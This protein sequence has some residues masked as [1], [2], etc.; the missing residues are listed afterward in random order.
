MKR[1]SLR[2]LLLALVPLLLV[3]PSLLPGKRFLPLLP[4]VMEPLTAEHPEAAERAFE[5]ANRVATD[6]LFPVLGEEREIREQ[7][8]AGELPT[9]NP[10]LGAGLPLA[11]GSMAAP[12]NPLRW[13]FLLLP[14]EV[15]GGWHVLLALFLA[16]LGMLLFL[17]RRGLAPV[18]AL[19]GAI[20]FQVGGFGAANLHYAMK[21]D[22][23]LWLPWCLWAVD[24][25]FAGRRFAGLALFFSLGA[26]ALAGFPPIFVFVLLLGTAWFVVRALTDERRGEARWRRIVGKG[27]AFGA[28]GILAGGVHLLPML[29]ASG[30][31]T[32]GPLEAREIG[33]QALPPAALATAVIP[34]L[35]GNAQEEWAAPADPAVWW[36]TSAVDR[37]R[38][39][40]ANRLEWSLFVGVSVVALA[41]SALLAATRRALFPALALV[42]VAFFIAGDPFARIFYS[43]PGLDL[44]NPARAGALWWFLFPW[45]A[46]LG[47]DALLEEKRLARGALGIACAAAFAL[48]FTLWVAID[49]E[50]WAEHLDATLITRHGVALET[51]RSVFTT[52]QALAVAER[53]LSGAR[54]LM[55]FAGAGGVLLII[56]PH[57]RDPRLRGAG[58]VALVATEGVV[59]ALPGVGPAALDREA[60]FPDSPAIEAIAEAAADGRVL[61]LDRSASGVD[62]VLRLARPNLLSAYGIDDLTPY[63]VFPPRYLVELLAALDP[64]SRYRGGVSR[65]SDPALLDHPILD[66]LRVSCVLSVAPVD[67]PRLE[68]RS[69]REGFFVYHRSGALSLARVVTRLEHGTAEELAAAPP[70]ADAAAICARAALAEDLATGEVREAKIQVV[71]SGPAR[72]DFQITEAPAGWLVVHEGW[73]PGWKATVNGRDTAVL[74]LD[75]ALRGVRIPAGLS[76]VRMKYE[77]LSL[78]LGAAASLLSLL[79]TLLFTW[80]DHRSSSRAPDPLPRPDAPAGPRQR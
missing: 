42:L 59:A 69:S 34:D 61:R 43:V 28:L 24:G 29:E 46:A 68:L 20:A 25:I 18:A 53:L 41:L 72:V 5:G 36:L 37:D 9:W 76:V 11:A 3:G 16:G 54:L 22:A 65:L 12:W 64:K 7:L 26:S 71:R 15:A 45:L 21:V 60:L 32:R 6:R 74:R 17:E 35:F 73:A 40:G 50:A 10:H 14:P 63:V 19:F 52:E 80:R 62:E 70:P 4:V 77:P 27:L 56:A 57:L 79:I 55:L 39:L 23:A 33:A 13:P 51:I 75:H 38:A 49:P 66:S 47:L 2:I 30:Q 58:W 1:T 8:L 48:G 67:H 31:S 44:G 78:R